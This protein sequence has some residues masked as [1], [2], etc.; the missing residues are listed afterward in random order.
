MDAHPPLRVVFSSVAFPY[1]SVETTA[2]FVRVIA[3]VVLLRSYTVVAV[4]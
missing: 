3:V 2:N 1:T 4:E